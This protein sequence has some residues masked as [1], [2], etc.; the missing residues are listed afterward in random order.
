MK[1][2]SRD[3][4]KSRDPGSQRVTQQPAPAKT[5]GSQEG[6][7]RV[8]KNSPRLTCPRGG[9][10]FTEAKKVS[11][12]LLSTSDRFDLPQ[13]S[14]VALAIMVKTKARHPDVPAAS[15]PGNPPRD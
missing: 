9:S 6:V 1:D 3:P 10:I 13:E 14:C 11:R 4:H 5:E 15:L 2:T 7:G 12:L 8:W